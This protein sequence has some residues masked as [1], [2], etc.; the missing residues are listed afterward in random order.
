M[1]MTRFIIPAAIL[2]ILSSVIT[3][4]GP[5]RFQIDRGVIDLTSLGRQGGQPAFPDKI[6]P[7]GGSNYST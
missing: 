7:T 1:M 5:C 3:A 6:P 2:T 4:D